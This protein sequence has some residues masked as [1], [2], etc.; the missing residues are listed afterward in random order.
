MAFTARDDWKTGDDYPADRMVELEAAV[1]A[2]AAK[3]DKGDAGDRGPA[4]ADGADGA[5]GEKGDKGDKG[6]PGE[7]GADLT[8]EVADL[9]TR[10]A[11]LEA[12]AE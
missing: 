3:G 4:G 6:D 11:A 7:P 1:E 8:A 2:K 12:A 10:V 9:E 5:R